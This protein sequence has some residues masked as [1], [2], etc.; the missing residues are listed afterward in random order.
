ME[1]YEKLYCPLTLLKPLL[2]LLLL[3]PTKRSLRDKVM[4]MTVDVL[5]LVY[6]SGVI[7][8]TG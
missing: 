1:G 5:I 6:V 3:I 2:S 8:M 7:M 4:C